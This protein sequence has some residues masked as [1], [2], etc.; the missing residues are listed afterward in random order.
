[1]DLEHVKILAGR[2]DGCIG[3]VDDYD[4]GRPLVIILRLP[5]GEPSPGGIIARVRESS[6]RPLTARQLAALKLGPTEV[7]EAMVSQ[8]AKD[9]GAAKRGGGGP[10]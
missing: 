3:Y 7:T 2:H 1:V 4:M 9:I 10:Q 5:N 6:C 8:E